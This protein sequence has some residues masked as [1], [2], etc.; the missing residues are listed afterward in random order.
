VIGTVLMVAVTVVLAAIVYLIV[1]PLVNPVEEPPEDIVLIQQGR[2][3][4]IDP[5]HWD[6]SY[7]IVE[8]RTK[9]AYL[10]N[11]CSFTC[12]G[13]HG[14]LITDATITPHDANGDGYITEGD[15]VTIAGMTDEYQGALFKIHY[16]GNMIGQDKVALWT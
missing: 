3:I 15:T 10:W 4:Q 13:T 14:S 11:S 16:M 7:N 1:S 5:T 8:V 2:I 12:Q 6:T 9:E